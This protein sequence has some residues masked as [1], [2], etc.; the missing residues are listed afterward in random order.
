VGVAGLW[1]SIQI[2][3]HASRSTVH[4]SHFTVHIEIRTVNNRELV[5]AIALLSPANKRP[6]L[7]GADAYEKKRQ[8]I[9]FQHGPPDGN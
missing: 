1:E 9:F 8:E 5:T 7:D 4:V 3:Q 6:R 2:T